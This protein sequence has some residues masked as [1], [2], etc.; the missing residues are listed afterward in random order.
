M[1]Y[2]EARRHWLP[3][4]NDP[5]S[6]LSFRPKLE[7]SAMRHE[8]EHDRDTIKDETRPTK[9]EASQGEA[10]LSEEQLA[11]ITG[12]ASVAAPG[13]FPVKGSTGDTSSPTAP[14]LP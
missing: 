4:V 13:N 2:R 14:T 6:L 5:E 7:E 3:V 11:S 1:R 12:G 9:D 10:E 8:H